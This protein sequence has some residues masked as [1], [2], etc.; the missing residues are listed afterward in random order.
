MTFRFALDAVLRFRESEEHSQEAALLRIVQEI[1]KAELQLR[2]VDSEQSRIRGQRE[3]DLALTLPAVYLRQVADQELELKNVADG[4]RSRLQKLEVQRLKQLAVFQ[5]ARQDR[6]V[7]SELRDQQRHLYQLEQKRQ[8]QKMLDD[9][10][11]AR[12]RERN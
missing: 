3:R 8:E 5:T 9:L 12:G 4:L 2:Q 1:A 10:F 7:L 11:L 6:Q